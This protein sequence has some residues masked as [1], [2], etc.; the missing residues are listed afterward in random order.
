[1]KLKALE[2]IEVDVLMKGASLFGEN[3]KNY[4]FKKGDQL[5]G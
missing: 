3:A 4:T 1:M 2:C 5:A